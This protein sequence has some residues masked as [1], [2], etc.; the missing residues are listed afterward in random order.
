MVFGKESRKRL[1]ESNEGYFNEDFYNIN[2][3]V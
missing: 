1:Y 2:K 3:K